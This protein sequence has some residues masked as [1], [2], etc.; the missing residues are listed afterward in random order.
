MVKGI[1]IDLLKSL[2][3]PGIEKV[4]NYL[5]ESDFFTAPAS[6]KF[7]S[8]FVGGLAEHSLQVFKVFNDKINRFNLDVPEDTRIIAGLL[9]DVCKIDT[10]KKGIRNVKNGKKEKWPGG[11][12]VDNWIEKEVWEKEDK[13]NLGH[14]EKSVIILQR[15]IELT[16]LEIMLI[17]F[18]MG[19]FAVQINEYNEAVKFYRA[20]IAL[21][22][23]DLESSHILEMR[24]E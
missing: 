13:F 20:I 9:H 18:H 22:T 16:D 6:T 17:R 2:E 8:C 12:L 19:P 15:M 7:H 24:G 21:Y 3:R 5:K 4:I 14:G 11:P 23:A 10:Y 1:I